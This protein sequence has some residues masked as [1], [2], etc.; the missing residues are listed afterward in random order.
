MM[1]TQ[2]GLGV[3]SMPSI[4][5]TMGIVPGIILILLIAGITTWA[6]WIVGVFKLRHPEVYGIDSIGRLFFGWIGYEVFGAAFC[7]RELNQLTMACTSYP[8]CSDNMF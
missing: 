7:L 6:D 1:K 8:V 3:L 2:I 5:H 4:F